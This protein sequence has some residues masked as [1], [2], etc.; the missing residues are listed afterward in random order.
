MESEYKY[1]RKKEM[2]LHNKCGFESIYSALYCEY[3]EILEHHNITNIRDLYELVLNGTNNKESLL[4]TSWSTGEAPS[5][6]I[7]NYLKEIISNT[8][9]VCG[10]YFYIISLYFNIHINIYYKYENQNKIH[11]ERMKKLNEALSNTYITNPSGKITIYCY[12]NEN[13]GHVYYEPLNKSKKIK[14]RFT[15]LKKQLDSVRLEYQ[16][17]E[18]MMEEIDWS[19]A[20]TR[21]CEE[22]EDDGFLLEDLLKYLT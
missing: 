3:P 8:G 15:T 2:D 17:M 6:S 22:E 18:E 4:E 12:R 21:A 11:N 13:Q 14:D 1:N 7:V 16:I 5:P 10:V 20:M 9:S 19:E